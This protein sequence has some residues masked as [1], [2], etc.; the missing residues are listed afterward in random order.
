LNGA[1]TTHPR[2]MGAGFAAADG[3]LTQP[4]PEQ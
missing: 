1:S 4:Q 2:F 3:P